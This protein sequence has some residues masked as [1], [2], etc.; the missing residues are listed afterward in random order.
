MSNPSSAQ[1]KSA[2]LELTSRQAARRKSALRKQ[3]TRQAI[4]RKKLALSRKPRLRVRTQADVDFEAVR[5]RR[6]ELERDI[7]PQLDD[8][9]SLKKQ[10]ASL[11][12]EAAAN[13]VMPTWYVE[14]GGWYV[15]KSDSISKVRRDAKAGS[16]DRPEIRKA[17]SDEILR[18][19][20]QSGLEIIDVLD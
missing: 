18:Y 7:K 13:R 1:R 11:M 20:A 8:L 9:E 10:E 5:R 2:R 15:I 6:Q 19:M 4:R 14:Q 12:L 16:F 17:T 3:A